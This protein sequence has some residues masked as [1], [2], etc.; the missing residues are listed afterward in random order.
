MDMNEADILAGR[1]KSVSAKHYSMYELDKIS[2]YYAQAWE[3]FGVN[4]SENFYF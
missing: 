4:I 3:K 1:A 2:E